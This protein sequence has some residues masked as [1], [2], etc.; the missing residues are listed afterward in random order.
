MR[1]FLSDLRFAARTLGRSR[2]FTIAAVL[3]ISVGIGANAAI[4]SVVDALLVRPLRFA[5][6][7]RLVVV[8]EKNIPRQRLDNVVSPGNF[9]HWREQSGRVFERLAAVSMFRITLTGV[10]EPEELPVQFVTSDLFPM[11]GVPAAHGRWLV[12]EE[13]RPETRVAMLSHALW[14]RRFNA[15]PAI[16]GRPITLNASHYTVVGV[17]P[18]GFSFLDRD[19]ALWIPIGFTPESRTPRGRWLIV[20]GRL[21]PGVS[22]AQAQGDMD[23]ITSRLT[24]T[25]P[26]FNTG[27]A[28]NV[29][30]LQ[31]QMVGRLRPALLTLVAAVAAVLLIACANVANLLLARGASRQR[32][33]AVRAALGAGRWRLVQQLL[34]ESLALA[35]IGAT[36]GLVMAWGGVMA[37]RSAAEAGV[38]I[39]RADG[40]AL[41]MRVVL[42]TAGLSVLTA[43]L[44]GLA[45]AFV[46]ARLNLQG[47]L[48]E[49]ARTGGSRS[50]GRARSALVVTEIAVALVLL[51]GAGLLVRSFTR[52]LDI[53]PGFRPDRTLSAKISLPG[54]RYET[55]EKSIRFFDTLVARLSGLPGVRAVGGVS[56]L[57]MTGVGAATSYTVVG[58][59]APA[60]GQEPVCDV[61]VATGNYFAAM[62]V[63][64]VAGRLFDDRD[65]A[66]K[67]RRVIINETMARQHWPNESPVGRHV[68]V[69]WNDKGPD[70][71]VGVVGDMRL[72][73]L[74]TTPRAAVYFPPGRFA[75]PWTTLVVRSSTDPSSLSVSIG[76]EVR[77]LDP[78]L[79]VADV[80][81]MDTV[82]S[83]SVAERRLVMNILTGFAAVAA[84]LAAIGVYGV[85][86]YAVTQRTREIGVRVAL[87][88]RPRDIASLVLRR[89]LMLTGV[90]VVIGAAGALAVT[91][92]MTALLF[93]TRPTDATV[94]ATVAA[95]LV[96]VAL[97]A[98]LFPSRAATRVDPLNAL[99]AE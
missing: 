5:D 41:N 62:G 11:L 65:S 73:G 58:R 92:Y 39:P 52:V 29:V 87:G 18:R 47:S 88:A 13:D 23:V 24:A 51:A 35:F 54:L 86:A 77:A 9:I 26:A 70:E 8:W 4:F 12:P 20:A 71:I 10:G 21:R 60:L 17:M 44:F 32:E 53:D 37:L 99:R 93:E 48:K 36:A 19:T 6:P 45:P 82:V 78:E 3:T 15:D 81:L 98:S 79:P 31:R 61:R 50:A 90:G 67:T 94:F 38:S 42:F 2:G 40:I 75:Y 97:L 96:A 1:C 74:E 89:A 83:R 85:M 33:L 80:R 16:V 91:R 30:L 84:L 57:P 25:F 72:E 28:S 63:P 66:P 46:A 7:D 49:G 22:V 55:P 27:W 56:F 69:S 76:R 59:P 95:T 34:A 64:L 14:T 43:A 68:I